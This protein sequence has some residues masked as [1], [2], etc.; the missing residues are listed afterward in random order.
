MSKKVNC[1]KGSWH[2]V[3]Y[4]TPW[5][6]D[7][8]RFQF[9]SFHF[10]CT[11]TNSTKHHLR[12]LVTISVKAAWWVWD[13]RWQVSEIVRRVQST[14]RAKELPGWPGQACPRGICFVCFCAANIWTEDMVVDCLVQLD[15]VSWK[16]SQVTPI[17]VDGDFWRTLR[18][19]KL[20]K[21]VQ[22]ISSTSDLVKV[23]LQDG[24]MIIRQNGKE[25]CSSLT[26]LKFVFE[27]LISLF[28]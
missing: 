18:D 3:L 8:C 9:S 26:A 7:V 2:P 11:S 22:I 27:K 19:F 12:C 16:R 5:T 13:S 23:V 21:A 28:C 20:L 14:Q 17:F 1:H 6:A 24:R 10:H 15:G 4:V 25:V